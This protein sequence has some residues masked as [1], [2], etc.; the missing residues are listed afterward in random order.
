MI[1][2]SNKL[3]TLYTW[4][5][6][7]NQLSFL[8]LLVIVAIFLFWGKSI[9]GVFASYWQQKQVAEVNLRLSSDI[10]KTY[11]HRPYEFH[12]LNNSAILFRNINSEVGQLVSY[13]LNP[14][15]AIISESIILFGVLFI[16][17]YLYPYATIITT[18]S[19]GIVAISMNKFFKRKM[20]K[21]ANER[22]LFSEQY[23]K[24]ATESLQTVKEI[25]IFNVQE[26]FAK[27]FQY[28]FSKYIN[29]FV[30]ST[31]ISNLPRY[32]LEALLFT[33]ILAVILFSSH[34]NANF[35]EILPM[36]AIMSVVAIRLMPSFYKIVMSL[37]AMNYAFNSLDMIF[38]IISHVPDV[39]NSDQ[40]IANNSKT[41]INACIKIDKVYFRYSGVEK[42]IL[43]NFSL[44]IQPHATT[45]FVGETGAGK[46][47]LIDI[48]MGL[49]LP[50]MGS[51]LYGD[52]NICKEYIDSYQRKIGY[53]PQAITLIDETIAANIAFGI[54]QLNIDPVK[55]ENA[56]NRSQL[57][58][59]IN[60]L[61]EGLST[62]I[63]ERG[64]RI[65]GGQRQRI[66]I[67]RAI[68]RNPE[69]IILDEATSALDVHTE[70]KVYEKIKELKKTIIIVTH[71]PTTL[72][73]TDIIY[74]LKDGK[75]SDYGTYEELREKSEYLKAISSSKYE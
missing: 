37:N 32:Y 19:I 23:Y 75:I 47:T 21:Y 28:S 54:P 44:I 35:K 70:R 29:S 45:A 56:A 20:T 51:V 42:Y 5:G 49:L 67:A 66:G 72:S 4:S 57:N 11:L 22:T 10:L 71:R 63:G 68:Y 30:K 24:V 12:L 64:M 46:S 69:I 17:I 33:G 14:L 60:E 6:A 58:E 25:T 62:V 2:T 48:I 16:S 18:M 15:I 39:S 8:T 74:V 40:K 36:I 34:L 50:Q 26:Y 53:V 31:T 61:P 1:N 38:D 43:K 41:N 52:K 59:F 27:K 7:E 55:L 65:S 73:F 13:V 3:R 9:F